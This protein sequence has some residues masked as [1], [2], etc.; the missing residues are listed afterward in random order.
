LRVIAGLAAF[1]L[2]TISVMGCAS[3]CPTALLEGTLVAADG[4]LVVE[5]QQAGVAIHVQWPFGVGVHDEGGTLVLADALG[6]VKAREG[7][8]VEIGGSSTGDGSW[9]ACGDI[10]VTG[11]PLRQAP[12]E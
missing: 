4:E 1:V 5:Q 10:A 12:S 9:V 6:T 7:D 8:A 11:S 2:A 3:G